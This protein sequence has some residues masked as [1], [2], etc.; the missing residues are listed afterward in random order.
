[1]IFQSYEFELWDLKNNT[2]YE[3]PNGDYISVTVPVKSG[4]QHHEQVRMMLTGQV[5]SIMGNVATD[6]QIRKIVKSADHYL[7]RKEIGGYRLN[8]DFQELK[9]DMGRMFGFAYGEKENGAVFS[10]MAVMYANA[11]YQRGFAKEGWKAS[12]SSSS[13]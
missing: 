8:T 9:F 5:F 3:I 10:H 7:Y 6:A 2:E 1:M 11:L 12:Q 4:Y 13:V